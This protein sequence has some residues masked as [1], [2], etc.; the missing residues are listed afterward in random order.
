MAGSE[1][2]EVVVSNFQLVSLI[3]AALATLVVPLLMF[4]V[5][6]AI[7]WSVVESKLD[8]AIGKLEEI[9]RDKDVTHKAMFQQ[10]TDDRRATDQ[11]L[12]WLEENV[13]KGRSAGTR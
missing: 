12:R 7:K 9:V 5:R 3:I 6:G 10:M 2:T 1:R 11:R 4:V 8:H 13:W